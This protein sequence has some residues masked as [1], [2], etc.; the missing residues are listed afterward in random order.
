[1]LK[2]DFILGMI[3]PVLQMVLLGLL[4]VRKVGWRF[5]IFFAYLV[6][7]SLVASVARAVAFHS[8]GSYFKLYWITEIGYGILAIL[9]VAP[10]GW[11]ALLFLS[12]KHG[13]FG[14][15][16]L[17]VVSAST[18]LSV[19][20]ATYHPLGHSPLFLL[21]TRAVA[22]IAEVHFLEV[23]LLVLCFVIRLNENSPVTWR[24]YDFGILEGFGISAFLTL[25][26]YL[27]VMI[28]GFRFEEAFRYAPTGAYAMATVYW[29]FV[30]A[31]RE[32]P[33]KNLEPHE[34]QR[35]LKFMQDQTAVLEKLSKLLGPRH[36]GPA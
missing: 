21:E 10:I 23:A 34:A 31:Q 24:S 19:W 25:L 1:M 6:Y 8:S 11:P 5:R 36:Y 15:M 4:L 22:F 20:W 2:Q 16:A 27:G 32:P 14:L 7:S 9:A 30:F 28:F 26:T 33:V 3:G 29:L 13:W 17:A 35:R 12:F 18:S